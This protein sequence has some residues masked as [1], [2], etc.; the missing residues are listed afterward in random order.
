MDNFDIYRRYKAAASR[1][2]GEHFETW[3]AAFFNALERDGLAAIQKTPEPYRQIGGTDS[4]GSFRAVRTSKAQADFAG[5]L[6]G[7]RA[8]YIEAKA[9][10]GDEIKRSRLRPDQRAFL[11]G[12]EKLG[13]VVLTA[14]GFQ[15]PT[16]KFDVFIV[17]WRAWEQGPA[18]RTRE[19]SGRFKLPDVLTHKAAIHIVNGWRSVP[20]DFPA[21]ESEEGE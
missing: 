4:K 20:E 11:S 2:T 10:E 5:V 6:K 8:V 1:S 18:K 21:P 9:T 12:R 19:N 17:P 14:L 16:G 15:Q 3:L 7:G 13:A